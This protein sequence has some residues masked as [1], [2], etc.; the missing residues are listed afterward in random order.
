M[1]VAPRPWAGRG[2]AIA[3]TM[4]DWT[5]ASA[6]VDLFVAG[7][8][9]V[10]RM[11][12]CATARRRRR[13]LFLLTPILALA[14][15]ASLLF[16]PV[17]L[18]R[19][20]STGASSPLAIGTGLPLAT[21]TG[22]PL[23]VPLAAASSA[24]SPAAAAHI[25]VLFSSGPM[26]SRSRFARSVEDD[27]SPASQARATAAQAAYLT[28]L[29]R[30]A[31]TRLLQPLRKTAHVDVFGCFDSADKSA[32]GAIIRRELRPTVLVFGDACGEPRAQRR[33]PVDIDA[34]HIEN[35]GQ[36]YRM[37]DC[38]RRVVRYEAARGQRYDYLIRVRPDL[39]WALPI[40]WAPENA[41]VDAIMMRYSRA[42]G[43]K[44]LTLAHFAKD[45]YWVGPVQ[46]KLVFSQFR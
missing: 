14:L 20:D 12:C 27:G 18:P 5:S 17:Q 13:C 41:G 15:C 32:L 4:N 19:A 16:H 34:F 9:A 24:R 36:F 8:V 22:L 6:E 38:F 37:S 10:P 40:A 3:M 43:I 23:A 21:G 33:C 25:G 45:Y 11:S 31:S 7:D 35:K 39:W 2:A 30:S 1:H 26:L 28:A 44:N 46:P 29:L 42:C